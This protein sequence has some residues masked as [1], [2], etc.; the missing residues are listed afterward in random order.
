MVKFLPSCEFFDVEG[1][2]VT[3]GAGEAATPGA[4]CA[5]WDTTPPR[6]FDPDSARRNG[7][8]ITRQQFL[9]LARLPA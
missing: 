2:P 4:Y 6:K 7:A 5:A 8:P 9:A 1:I 3:L